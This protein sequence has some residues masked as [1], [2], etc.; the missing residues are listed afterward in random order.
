MELGVGGLIFLDKKRSKVFSNQTVSFF[1][2]Q[3]EQFNEILYRLIKANQDC[4]FII[5]EHPGNIFGHEGSA[6]ESSIHFDNV[7][8]YKNDKSMISCLKKSNI[9]ITYDS[10][11]AMEAWLMGKQTCLINPKTSS[12]PVARDQIHTGQPIALSA[13]E[14]I[15]FIS[16]YKKS[17][18][19]PGFMELESK[20]KQIIK[21]IVGWTDGLNHVRAGNEI[22]KFLKGKRS[23]TKFDNRLITPKYIHIIRQKDQMGYD[24]IFFLA[25][26]VQK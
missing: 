9:W 5:K 11:T 25:Q 1:L 6:I 15:D 10:T 24:E 7:K 2:D 22:I 14:I 19:L 12:W 23:L 13:K 8:I 26:E 18:C 4:E 20:R 21:D 16:C 17:D 3:R